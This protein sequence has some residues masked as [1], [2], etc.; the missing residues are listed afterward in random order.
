MRVIGRKAVFAVILK[1]TVRLR[2][3]RGTELLHFDRVVAEMTAGIG[4]GHIG[5][6][7][8]Q[9]ADI[10]LA[11]ALGRHHSKRHELLM[12][13]CCHMQRI[14]CAALIRRNRPDM[15]F[16]PARV[17]DIIIVKMDRTVFAR[18][19]TPVHFRAGPV[20]AAD[21][22]LGQMHGFTMVTIAGHVFQALTGNVG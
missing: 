18:C 5:R 22:T 16:R 15:A 12:L 7:G 21:T 6:A 14:D 3:H 9:E 19:M 8:Q 20:G 4:I 10:R 1:K 13:I 11:C 17:V 2:H